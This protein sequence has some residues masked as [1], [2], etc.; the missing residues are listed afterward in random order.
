MKFLSLTHARIFAPR[1]VCNRALN[2]S[3]IT[4]IRPDR[5]TTSSSVSH[6]L[7]GLRSDLACRSLWNRLITERTART[8]GFLGIN[9]HASLYQG[10]ICQDG[11]FLT[12]KEMLL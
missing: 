6:S 9:A 7:F 8:G 5:F 1:H 11:Y 2:V 4:I 10:A 3:R 12:F